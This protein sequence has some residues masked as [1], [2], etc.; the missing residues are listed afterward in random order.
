MDLGE[1]R[2]PA[3]LLKNISV[4]HIK[5]GRKRFASRNDSLQ[6]LLRPAKIILRLFRLCVRELLFESREAFFTRAG[7]W[8]RAG[9]QSIQ[10]FLCRHFGNQ[11]GIKGYD[12]G[13]RTAPKFPNARGQVNCH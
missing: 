7:L 13:P 10:L 6:T 8:C 11:K 4:K 5:L 1:S 9:F 3:F 2:L 12:L